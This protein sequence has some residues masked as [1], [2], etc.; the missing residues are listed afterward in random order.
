M[1][2]NIPDAWLR[3]GQ[4][5]TQPRGMTDGVK[6]SGHFAPADA[7]AMRAWNGVSSEGKVSWVW[8]RKIAGHCLRRPSGQPVLMVDLIV[9]LTVWCGD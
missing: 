4:L 1:R 5:T 6:G 3:L 2:Q 9:L 7:A 8:R